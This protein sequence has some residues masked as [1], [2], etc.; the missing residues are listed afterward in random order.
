LEDELDWFFGYAEAALRHDR[1]SMLPSHAAT[2]ARPREAKPK[3]RQ[4]ARTVEQCLGG[5]PKPHAVV[6]RAAFTPRHWPRPLHDSFK[7]LSPIVVRLFGKSDPWPDRVSH[8]GLEDATAL[9]LA[10]SLRQGGAQL[11]VLREDA[12]R[13]FES[14]ITA[15]AKQRQEVSADSR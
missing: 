12:Q 2:G 5:L 9:Q 14:A 8:Q 6:L 10:A 4:L 15:Y 7:H 1:L 11:A 3:A 13:L